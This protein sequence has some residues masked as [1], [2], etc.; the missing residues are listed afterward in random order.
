MIQDLGQ[1]VFDNHFSPHDPAP[2]SPVLCFSPE[3]VLAR[4]DG[5]ALRYPT[6]SETGGPVQY[7]FSLGGEAYF[8][9][10][11][12][13]V[14]GYTRTHVRTL[15]TAA[16]K[17]AA[18]AG[19]TGYHL[20]RWYRDNAYCG[21]CGRPLTHAKD[22]RALICECGNRVYPK[23]CPA[24]IV[25]VRNNGRVLLTKYSRPDAPWALVAGFAEIGET[26]EQTVAREVMEEC[27]L[28]VKNIRYYKSQPWGFSGDLLSGF[29]CDLDGDDTIA[30]DRAELKTAA[31]F[32]P[33]QIRFADDGLSLT[34]E[35]ID[36]FRRGQD[37]L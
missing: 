9:G 30:L 21:R 6:F 35:M 17:P 24:V 28:R 19:I 22:E 37:P 14:P 2:D 13:S 12:E 26:L 18:F 15:R 10:H 8:L 4:A 11:A 27:G 25:A 1:T 7:C 34:R 29:F 32:L 3:G 5:G 36:V 33:G 20:W 23:L 31:W 16:P